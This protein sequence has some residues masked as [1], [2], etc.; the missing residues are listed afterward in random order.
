[1]IGVSQARFDPVVEA[2]V[3]ATYGVDTLTDT[4]T[5]RRM[6]VLLRGLPAGSV[7]Q[8]TDQAAAWS[9]EAH[10]LATLVDAVQWNTWVLMRVNSKQKPKEPK[11]TP[12]PGRRPARRGMNIRDLA[13]ALS[14][15]AGVR[16]S[17][18]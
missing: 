18:G 9:V 5:P 12:R 2:A 6:A 1:M 7:Q 17:G 4:L 11:P 3:L 16:T 8:W 15:V 10:L 13:G 14:G